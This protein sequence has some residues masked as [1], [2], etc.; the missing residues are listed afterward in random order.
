MAFNKDMTPY[1]AGPKTLHV[2]LLLDVSGSMGNYDGDSQNLSRIEA[3]NQSVDSMLNSFKFIEDLKLSMISFGDCAN[4]LMCGASPKE[5]LQKWQPLQADGM[6]CL[7]EALRTVSEMINDRNLVVPKR[8]YTPIVIVLSD[9]GPNDDWKS[10]LQE[11]KT[12]KRTGKCKR[13][14]MAIGSGADENVLNMFLGDSEYQLFHADDSDKIKDFFERVVLVTTTTLGKATTVTAASNANTPAT[15]GNE[16]VANP[17]S[18]APNQQAKP[19]HKPS[20]FV[21]LSSV[22]RRDYNNDDDDL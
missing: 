9:G 7:G 16:Q 11:F 15:N 17:N 5:A 13:M 3:V 8:S 21:G 4:V 14:A 20:S 18:A 22:L 1:F 2:F 6:T 12:G 19:Q 10:A